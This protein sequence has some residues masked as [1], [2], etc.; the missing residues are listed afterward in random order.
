MQALA[1]ITYIKIG[2][3]NR[4]LK[5]GTNQTHKFCEIRKIDLDVYGQILAN[6]LQDIG[7]IRDFLYSALWAGAVSKDQ[8]FDYSMY[9][10]GDWMD[11][12]GIESV[13]VTLTNALN[14]KIPNQ[15]GPKAK[16]IEVVNP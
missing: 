1:E 4:P 14:P 15:P 11:E 6:G 12:T 5:F 7:T 3:E 13:L 2:G 16:K 9:K 8:P 10:V